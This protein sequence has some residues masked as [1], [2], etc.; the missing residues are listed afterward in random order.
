MFF[1]MVLIALSAPLAMAESSKG[2]VTANSLNV[3]VKPTTAYSTVASLPRGTEVEVLGRN[4]DWYEITAPADSAVWIAAEF[5]NDGE[6]A[7]NVN[8][9]PGPGLAYTSYG[10][11]PKGEKVTIIGEPHRGWLKIRPPRGLSAW[12]HA[13]YIEL[14][15]KEDADRLEA[16]AEGPGIGARGELSL[17]SGNI[18]TPN[19]ER[20]RER[21]PE[22]IGSLPFTDDPE[23]VVVTG[24]IMP[25]YPD[26]VY[27]T[28]AIVWETDEGLC[29]VA[30]L[31]CDW[32]DLSPMEGTRVV[33]DGRERPVFG[34]R[35]P[36]VEVTGP[37]GMTA[38]PL[39][40][41]NCR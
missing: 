31:R 11:L 41:E 4:G 23:P 2:K 14:T 15:E 34:W 8:L 38:L 32:A 30:Y 17:E 33:I 24:K 6:T 5:L 7:A 27:V 25:L 10:I 35:R 18:K 16:E 40:K 37:R 13:N 39:L 36:V 9:R 22:R 19:Y 1:L 3:R 12:V 26:A 21:A 20:A 28:H 29:P